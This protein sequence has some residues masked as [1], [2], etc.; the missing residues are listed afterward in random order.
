MRILVCGGRDFGNI[1]RYQ[2]HHEPDHPNVR[3]AEKEYSFIM[4]GLSNLICQYSIHYQENDNW[5]P[6]D[7]EIIS[8]MASGVDSVAVDFAAC[9]WMK[10]HEYLADWEKYGKA[11]GPIR[12]KRMLL[13]G[14]PDLV[15]AFPGGRGT[16]NMIKLA[17]EAGVEVLEVKY[18]V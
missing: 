17:K 16:M 13:E 6:S 11:A 14:R 10:T 4:E 2:Q 5:L 8:G 3:K 1:D 18:D 15:V 9:N 12:N 7:I